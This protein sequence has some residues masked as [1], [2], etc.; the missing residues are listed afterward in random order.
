[1]IG[2]MVIGVVAMRE[3]VSCLV[4]TALEVVLLEALVDL[5]DR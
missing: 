2:A 5:R 4:S 1:M 3:A